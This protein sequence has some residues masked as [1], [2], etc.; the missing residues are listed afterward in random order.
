MSLKKSNKRSARSV[1]SDVFK[2]CPECQ[3]RNLLRF[4]GEALCT[5]CDW[6]SISSTLDAIGM[7]AFTLGGDLLAPESEVPPM[8]DVEAIESQMIA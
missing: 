1:P 7:F 5:R 8:E 6:S 3:E 4:D 2:K